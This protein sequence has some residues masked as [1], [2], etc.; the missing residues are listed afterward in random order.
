MLLLKN[1]QFL[2]DHYKIL[3][4]EGSHEDLILTKFRNDRVKIVDFLVKAYFRPSPET[5]GT[6]CIKIVIAKFGFLFRSEINLIF[7]ALS[8]SGLLIFII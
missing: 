5:P 6:Q 7:Y 2:S 3:T 4:K 1:P 8:A